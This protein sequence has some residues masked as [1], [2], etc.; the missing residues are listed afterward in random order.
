MDMKPIWE[1]AK[2]IRTRTKH[3]HCSIQKMDGSKTNDKKEILARWTE[4][5]KT[6]RHVKEQETVPTIQYI[7]EIYWGGNK[8]D[9]TRQTEQQDHQIPPHIEYVG[10]KPI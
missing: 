9:I 6:Q 4:Y 1:Y 2:K 5:I 10:E 8:K 3:K 7:P